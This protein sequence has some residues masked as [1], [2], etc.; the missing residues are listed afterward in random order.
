MILAGICRLVS[1]LSCPALALLP[2]ACAYAVYAVAHA[3]HA[4]QVEGRDLRDGGALFERL[5]DVRFQGLSEQV[6]FNENMD[7]A[8]GGICLLVLPVLPV[9]LVLLVL[10]VKS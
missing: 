1:L 10:L 3:L 7:P 5:R 8:S 4:L 9:L 6:S 2:L